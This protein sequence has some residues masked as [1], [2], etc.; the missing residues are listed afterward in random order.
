MKSNPKDGYVCQ[1]KAAEGAGKQIPEH[2]VSY[3]LGNDEPRCALRD[4]GNMVQKLDQRKGIMEPSGIDMRCLTCPV[5]L[6]VS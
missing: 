3:A 6:T 5:K 4:T 1:V 2:R